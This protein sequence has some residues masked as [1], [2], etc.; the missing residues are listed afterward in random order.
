M[1]ANYQFY[2]QDISTE[3]KE[4]LTM[5]IKVFQIDNLNYYFYLSKKENVYENITTPFKNE[6]NKVLIKNLQSINISVLRK[7]E[8]D[9][10]YINSIQKENNVFKIV[11]IKQIPN[12]NTEDQLTKS[13]EK[14]NFLI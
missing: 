13:E 6:D 12:I 4:I 7:E 2:K 11:T 14:K 5:Y 8:Q 1:E 10:Y 3:Q 9:F